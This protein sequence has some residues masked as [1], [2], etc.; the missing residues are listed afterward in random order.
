MTVA[1]VTPAVF[2]VSIDTL[3]AALNE[4]WNAIASAATQDAINRLGPFGMRPGTPQER[5]ASLN[6]FLREY[7]ESGLTGVVAARPFKM[8]QRLTLQRGLFLVPL[9]LN[10]SFEGQLATVL[11][12]Y[13]HD[14]A[15]FR[16]HL[17]SLDRRSVLAKLEEMN[18]HPASL[19]PGLD[20]YA[21]SL[22]RRYEIHR[23]NDLI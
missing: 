11:G 21:Q 22:K 10:Y 16:A 23:L 20:G 13:P 3:E 15:L 12:S 8:N 18:I 14:K 19:F 17:K 1:G 9:S 6:T 7:S 2:A 5:T 4:R